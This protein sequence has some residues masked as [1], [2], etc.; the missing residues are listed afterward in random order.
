MTSERRVARLKRRLYR[1]LAPAAWP[2]EGLSP[3][4]QFLCVTIVLSAIV[5]IFES[6]PTIYALSPAGF[7]LAELAFCAVFL[8]EYVARVFAAG[9]DP[10]YA[11]VFGRIRY[12]LTP[13]AILDLLAIAPSLI[14]LW[15]QDAMLLRILR[16]VRI[17]RLARLGRF[18]LAMQA[19]VEA[20]GARRYEL[21]LSAAMSGIV[22]I[23][24]ATV[25][26]AVEG[27][28]QPEAFGSIPRALWWAVATLTT[29][30]YG[31][32]YPVT[33]A[34]RICGALSAIAAIGLIA[35]PTGIVAAAFSDAFAKQRQR[36]KRPKNHDAVDGMPPP[37]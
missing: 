8:A 23:F 29:V 4:N 15:G 3:A 21:G 11:G 10:R 37:E 31:D 16:L 20:I 27:A 2:R 24:S 30:G 28:D 7:R 26:H 25:M 32:V 1:H 14:V 12:M 17:L 6:E 36:P 35:M 18:S 9:E 19:L 22:L 34:G 13:M 33:A 5:V